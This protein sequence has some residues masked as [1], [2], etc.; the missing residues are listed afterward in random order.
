MH[1]AAVTLLAGLAA[2]AHPRED[3]E[4]VTVDRGCIS[5]AKLERYDEA[6]QRWFDGLPMSDGDAEVLL[7]VR[8]AAAG[9]GHE[10]NPETFS[11]DPDTK[12]ETPRFARP[13]ATSPRG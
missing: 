1:R 12:T 2:C 3:P 13:A 5:D 4:P 8:E 9:C 6:W 11:R 7:D 10:R